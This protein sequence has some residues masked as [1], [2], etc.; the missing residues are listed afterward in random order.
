MSATSIILQSSS[1]VKGEPRKTLTIPVRYLGYVRILIGLW[2]AIWAVIELFL[3]ASLVRMSTAPTPNPS[4]SVASIGLLLACFTL[5]GVFMVWRLAWVSK[6]REVLEWTPRRLLVDRKPGLGKTLEFDRAGI[7]N[8][9][10]GSY[11]GRLI[12]PSWGRSFLG[13]EEYFVGFDYDGK[14]REIARGVRRRDAERV[15]TLLRN[16]DAGASARAS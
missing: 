10:I 5:A 7:R 4:A 12:Y 2:L 6:G 15:L 14:A 1:F 16:P 9:H 13:K 8:L 11:A 3:A